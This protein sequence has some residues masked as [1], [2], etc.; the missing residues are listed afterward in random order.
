[1]QSQLGDFRIAI[2]TY[3]EAIERFG[4]SEALQLLKPVARSLCNKGAALAALGDNVAAIAAFDDAIDRF[5]GTEAPELWEEVARALSNLG[6]VQAQ[7]GNR[8]AAMTAY[9]SVIGRFGA[10][11]TPEIRLSVA[12]ALFGRGVTQAELGQESDALLTC[13]EL[14]RR[15][16]AMTG[17][18]KANFA[19]RVMWVRAAALIA[20]NR[21]R[22]AIG[23]VPCGVCRVPARKRCDHAL[24]AGAC[25]G[26]DRNRRSRVRNHRSPFERQQEIGPAGATDRG[27]ASA[28]WRDG[29]R[30]RGGAR[31]GRGCP[32][33]YRGGV[34]A[35][36]ILPPRDVSPIAVRRRFLDHVNAAVSA[37]ASGS[38]SRS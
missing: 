13:E 29:S 11:D 28:R 14:E 8:T 24:D 3:D 15:V 10:S 21:R 12:M 16:E 30:T 17:T 6:D 19:W 22:A 9:D 37:A 31:G 32:Q 35:S 1:M 5:G 23:R 4:E 33:A 7:E 25:A 18:A 34:S 27:L 38:D 2:A 20:Q 26:T 36:V